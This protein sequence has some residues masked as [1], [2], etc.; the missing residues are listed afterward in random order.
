MRSDEW[1]LVE[2]AFAETLSVSSLPDSITDIP[3]VLISSQELHDTE[4]FLSDKSVLWCDP[5]PTCNHNFGSTQEVPQSLITF[6]VLVN[7]ERETADKIKPAFI[8]TDLRGSIRR[9]STLNIIS[10]QID[11]ELG[12]LAAFKLRAGNL[13]GSMYKPDM[14]FIQVNRRIKDRASMILKAY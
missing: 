9:L 5:N 3:A 12:R 8:Q 6:D 13:V 1:I 11:P 4:L 10:P 14:E 2:D 7:Q